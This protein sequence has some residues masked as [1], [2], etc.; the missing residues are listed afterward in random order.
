MYTQCFETESSQFKKRRRNKR[1]RRQAEDTTRTAIA[2][3]LHYYVVFAL[4]LAVSVGCIT[5]T[6]SQHGTVGYHRSAETSWKTCSVHNCMKSKHYLHVRVYMYTY[7]GTIL[8]SN[9]G[10]TLLP[11]YL[12]A[13]QSTILLFLKFQ[14]TTHTWLCS[15][16]IYSMS[17]SPKVGILHINS[18][19]ERFYA[20]CT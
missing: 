8:L 5:M 15:E 2:H 18:L 20:T 3:C 11:C 19:W 9:N 4:Y 14:T 16:K 17:K 7:L 12:Y 13:F 6:P 1:K 10:P